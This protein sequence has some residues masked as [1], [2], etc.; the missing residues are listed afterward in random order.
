MS[1]FFPFG[2]IFAFVLCLIITLGQNYQAFLQDRIDWG[3]RGGDLHR[4]SAVPADLGGLPAGAR[5]ALRQLPRHALPRRP[6]AQLVP[7]FGAARGS[8]RGNGVG[9]A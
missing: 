9:R 4:H 3:R 2:P 5:L 1:P 7:G 8:G 6:G